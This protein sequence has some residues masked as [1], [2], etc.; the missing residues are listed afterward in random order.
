M[1][2]RSGGRAGTPHRGRCA[3][4]FRTVVALLFCVLAGS[5]CPDRGTGGFRAALADDD[6]RAGGD[7]FDDGRWDGRDDYGGREAWPDP[8]GG[9]GMPLEFER[10]EIVASGLRPEDIERLRSRGFVPVHQRRLATLAL[11]QVRFRIPRAYSIASATQLVRDVS[12]GAVADANHLY[13]PADA[14]DACDGRACRAR[15]LVAWRAPGDTCGGETTVGLIDTGVAA[16]HPW[17]QGARIEALVARSPDRKAA[18]KAHGTAVASVIVGRAPG[19][20]VGLMP[21]ARLVAVDAFHAGAGGD[22]MDA[23]DLLAAIDQLLALRVRVINLS[24]AGPANTLVEAA[25]RT[26]EQ[27][28]AVLIAAVGNEGPR[29][30]PQYPAAYPQVIAVTAVDDALRVYRRAVQGDHVEIGAPGV[31]VPVANAGGWLS[32][33][34]ATQSGTSI[35]APFVAASA[36]A[37]VAAQPRL[38]SVEVRRRLTAGARDLGAPGRDAVF[39]HGLLQAVPP[40]G[41]D[42]RPDAPPRRPAP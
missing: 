17:L 12:S 34:T 23:F 27:R 32:R 14:A 26:A 28:G 5:V 29:A 9:A 3:P 10:D 8:G 20:V 35:A 13:R 18:A 6:D 33:K 41:P 19:E 40:C 16:E 4:L 37:I 42:R 15:R 1:D 39:G 24:F 7:R 25:V 30:S 38:T 22:R 11:D 36:A 21:S 2:R 31:D